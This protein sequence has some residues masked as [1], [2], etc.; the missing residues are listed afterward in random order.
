MSAVE[1]PDFLVAYNAVEVPA[2]ILSQDAI[3]EEVNTIKENFFAEIRD[4]LDLSPRTL[5]HFFDVERRLIVRQS[6]A[7]QG[8]FGTDDYQTHFRRTGHQIL[9]SV[10]YMRDDFNYQ[11]AHFAKHTL[12]E[13][14]VSGI[15]ELQQLERIEFGIE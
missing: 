2:T 3:D 12:L 1:R 11:V 8:Y 5:E 10:T 13:D 15:R 14:T 7:E 4:S 9:A 6:H